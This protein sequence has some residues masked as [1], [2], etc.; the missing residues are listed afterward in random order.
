MLSF[1]YAKASKNLGEN[2][3]KLIDFEIYNNTVKE[4]FNKVK[5]NKSFGNELFILSTYAFEL[6]LDQNTFLL[7][8]AK[9]S[10]INIASASLK[11]SR[12][13]PTQIQQILFEFDNKIENII[14][15]S[16]NCPNNF[17]PL[18]EEIIFCHK[19]LEPKLFTT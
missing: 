2:Y 7:F 8:W 1:E 17:N 12:I 9:K 5:E 4:Y 13:K 11:I 6:G 16:S 14:E 3:L 18:F 10:L 19:Q 15:V